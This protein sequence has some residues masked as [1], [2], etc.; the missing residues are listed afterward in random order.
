MDDVRSRTRSPSELLFGSLL[1]YAPQGTS[2][3]SVQSQ[4]VARHI[5]NCRTTYI[6]RVGLRFR[7][8]FERG[9]FR[10]MLGPEVALVPVPRSPPGVK[11]MLWP[12]LRICEELRERGLGEDVERLLERHRAVAKSALTSRGAERPSPDEHEA[13]LRCV[14]VLKQ[15]RGHITIVD[16][17]VTRGS[18][19]LGCA[20]TLARCFPDATIRA[21]AVVRTMSGHEVEEILAPIDDGRIY[22][23][24]GVPRREP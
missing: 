18:T 14:S 12:A 5:K 15:A 8:C 3:P 13:S 9:L 23:R 24:A 21:L 10:D 1:V 6:R 16:D 17:V 4:Q 2:E 22:M 11:D 7:E 20:W 19:L